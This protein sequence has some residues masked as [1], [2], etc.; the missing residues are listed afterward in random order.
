MSS[1]NNKDVSTF[2]GLIARL[3][4]YWSEQGCADIASLDGSRRGVPFILLPSC[5]LSARK[6][7]TRPA[8]NLL[9][10]AYR[11]VA[12]R[13]SQ[14]PTTLLPISGSMK[15]SQKT[16]L[17][18]IWEVSANSA[19]LIRQFTMCV[20][21]RDNWESTHARCPGVSVGG[22]AKWNGNNA[23]HLFPTNWWPLSVIPVTGEITYGLERI[24]AHL[25]VVSIVSLI[26][27]GLM[28]PSGPVT[29]GTFFHQK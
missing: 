7:G 28:G 19:L 27:F 4:N 24:A 8:S 5:A 3:Q 13:K 2:Q 12:G 29:Y 16:S 9:S 11:M 20:L 14:S 23:V 26:S 15:P 6:T 10:S 1:A 22:L 21:S 17:N 18:F 25:Q